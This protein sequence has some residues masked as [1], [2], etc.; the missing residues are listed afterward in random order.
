MQRACACVARR[1]AAVAA[2]IGLAFGPVT[3]VHAG[4]L[5]DAWRAA[6]DADPDLRVAQAARAVGE[7]R[8]AQARSLWAPQVGLSVSAGLG[9]SESSVDGARFSAAPF[10]TIDGAAFRTS[11]DGPSGR[12]AVAARQPVWSGERRA[13][14]RQLELAGELAG[15]EARAAEQDA[16]LRTAQRWFEVAVA[17]QALRVAQRQQGAV[18]RSL[19]EATDRWRIG[20]APVVGT[21]EARARAEA[22]RA[23][24]IAARTELA[25]RR[26]ALAESTGRG[27]DADTLRPGVPQAADVPADAPLEPLERWLERAAD[28]NAGLG[29]LALAVELARQDVAKLERGAQASVDLI[30]QAARDRIVGSGEFGGASAGAT[31]A[32]VGVQLNVPLWTG[33]AREA[34]RDEALRQ[35]G[36]AEAELDRAR[37][38]VV[39]EVRAAWLQLDASA[40]RVTALE[41]ARTASAARL[42]STRTGHEVGDRTTLDVLNAENDFAQSELAL[43]QARVARLVDRLRLAALAGSLD[44][45]R[46]AEADARLGPA[47]RPD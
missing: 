22:V 36:K 2:A 38:R 26:A 37:L 28:G 41:Q 31:Q 4:G 47:A 32:L 6:R 21:H 20:D 35:V 33:G 15:L 45:A 39:R 14:S 9:R 12:L 17:E 43:A 11:V 24:V 34:R 10:G 1:A 27:A 8:A 18:D 7:A 30:A 46:L 23:Q 3:A 40:G 19:A 16:M 44:E 29:A 25:L 13:Q 5:V 42:A